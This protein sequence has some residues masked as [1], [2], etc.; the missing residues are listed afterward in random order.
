MAMTAAERMARL[1]ARQRVAGLETLTLVVPVDDVPAFVRLAAR[2]RGLDQAGQAPGAAVRLSR[3]IARVRTTQIS[4][5]DILAFRELLEVTAVTLVARRM[6]GQF[7][8]RLRAEIA[9]ESTLPANAGAAA[10]QRLH[11]LLGD[12][13]GD[14]AL[15]L[16]LR[17]ALQ[18][19]DERSPFERAR[20]PERERI[21][22]RV[23]QLHAG[24][25]D[26]LVERNEALAIRR[27]RRYLSGL[28]EWLE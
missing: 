4:P 6:N 7:V 16:L 2:R 24:I 15:Q 1:R 18:L 5:A 22:A 17:I 14:D 13:S 27:M 28:R 23:K 25:V 19:T 3:R 26:E 12:L 11:L 21:V 8:R 9:R 10:W 20:E